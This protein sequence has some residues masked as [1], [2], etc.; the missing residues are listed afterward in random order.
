MNYRRTRFTV[1]L[2]AAA[3]VAGLNS[4]TDVV[5]DF[6]LDQWGLRRNSG[7]DGS[8]HILCAG[9]PVMAGKAFQHL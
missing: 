7:I 9:Q 2:C 5:Y 6:K 8:Q 4:S 3:A 1:L